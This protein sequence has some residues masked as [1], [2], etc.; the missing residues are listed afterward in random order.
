[1]FSRKRAG[2]KLVHYATAMYKGVQYNELVGTDKRHALRVEARI[3]REIRE[4]TFQPKGRRT[5]AVTAAR[6]AATWGAA[7]TNRT[8]ND[9]RQRLRDS[10]SRIAVSQRSKTSSCRTGI[11]APWVAARTRSQARTRR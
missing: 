11:R 10:S 7:R 5:G 9:D 8:A 3:R 4:E 6:Y 2:G 1:M